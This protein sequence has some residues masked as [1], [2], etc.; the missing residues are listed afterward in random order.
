MKERAHVVVSGRVQGVF[1]RYETKREAE[2]RGVTGWVRNLHDGRL[3]AVFEGEEEVGSPHLFSFARSHADLLREADGCLWEYGY[4]NTEGRPV[5]N[6]GVKG[7]VAVELH[8]RTARSDEDRRPAFPVR[9]Q[10]EL[11]A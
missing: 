1:F 9:N 2:K 3:E 7:I 10:K 6:L 5:V 8:A 11:H 4:K